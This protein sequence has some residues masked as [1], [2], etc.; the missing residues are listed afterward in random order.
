ME[1]DKKL[2]GYYNAN[3]SNKLMAENLRIVINRNKI[4]KAE[5]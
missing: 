5:L 4:V 2:A 1:K 3:K